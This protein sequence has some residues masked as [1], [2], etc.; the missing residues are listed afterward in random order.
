MDAGFEARLRVGGV[1]FEADD[2]A[3]LRAVDEHR[4]LNAAADALGRS[5][6]RAHE[7]VEALEGAVGPLVERRRGGPEGGGSELTPD[8]RRLLARFDRL[9]A[10]LEGTA[11]TR[12]AVLPG[13]VTDREGELATV[14][15]SIGPVRALLFEDGER[16]HVTF[17]AHAVTLHDPASAPAADET[18]ALN[19]FRGTVKGIDRREAIATV[20]I[21][22]GGGDPLPALITADSL[23]RLDLAP[24]DA[25]VASFKATAARATPV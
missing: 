2:A 5:Y 10:A 18:S 7:R 15:T 22:V 4:S 25:V 24:G 3:L 1:T 13:T 11:N 19:R 12:E 8:A 9:R 17:R 14:E 6:S 23:D 16:V 20:R 21:D